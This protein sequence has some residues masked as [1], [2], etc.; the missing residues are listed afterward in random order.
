VR[1]TEK[2]IY[3]SVRNSVMDNRS[4]LFT[5]QQKIAENRR[6]LYLSD[7]PRSS[8][9]ASQIKTGQSE[10]AQFKRNILFGKA[11]LDLTENALNG[12]ND[13]LVRA[14]ELAIQMANGEVSASDR[15]AA[16]AEVAELF[17][18]AVAYSNTKLGGEYIFSGFKSD[19]PA[20]TDDGV[21][22]GDEG[23]R[24]VRIGQS[25]KM[26]INETG[27]SV[28]G[29]RVTA[30]AV[31]SAPPPGYV[32][33]SSIMEDLAQFRAA[34]EN[35]DINGIQTTIAAMDQ[36]QARVLKS[37]ASVGTR[38]KHMQVTDSSL[39]NLST[40]LT[41]QL[42]DIQDLDIA[43]MAID[44]AKQEAVLN[45]SIQVAGRI[46]SMTVLDAVKR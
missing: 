43:Q 33:G 3:D 28:F 34:L 44:L 45:A 30:G 38:T 10:V 1:I 41:A 19:T 35:N 12:I 40:S 4:T 21:W 18:Q 15:Q 17:K 5:I 46:T 42:S 14:K 13:T 32:A 29:N 11:S 16:A 26:Q 6:L 20:Y 25:E 27:S 23:T 7:D 37:Q 8:E 24:L 22:Q 2:I 9:K 39:L 31:P 36:G